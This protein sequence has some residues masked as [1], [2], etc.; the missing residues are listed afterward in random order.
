MNRQIRDQSRVSRQHPEEAQPV[1][2][3]DG[4]FEAARLPARFE[5]PAVEAPARRLVEASKLDFAGQGLV[6]G[7]R[8]ADA[9]VQQDAPPVELDFPRYRA[10]LDTIR[11]VLKNRFVG[12]GVL[13]WNSELRWRAADF[14][15]VGKPF[16]VVLSAFLDQGRVWEDAPDFGEIFSDLHRGYGGGFRIGMGED[17]TVAYDLGTSSD[18]GLQVYIGLGYLY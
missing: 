8:T 12:R 2:C 3:C 13:L 18:T 10:Y 16:H 7:A 9:V 5:A 14:R 17:F 1:G 11:G 6:E 4:P 15:F